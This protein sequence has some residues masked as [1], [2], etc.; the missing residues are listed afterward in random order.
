MTLAGFI[1]AIGS[2]QTSSRL[3]WSFARDDALLFSQHLKKMD[4]KLGVPLWALLFNAFWLFIIGC[5]YLASSYGKVHD[6]ILKRPLSVKLTVLRVS[7]QCLHRDSYDHRTH[8]F[9][10]PSSSSHVATS[11]PTVPT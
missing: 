10:F 9:R 3:T 1:A 11:S 2:V 4:P 5:I 6:Q 7:I 8:L